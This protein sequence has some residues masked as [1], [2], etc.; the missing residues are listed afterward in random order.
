MLPRPGKLPLPL[1]L[2][3][4]NGIIFPASLP[5]FERWNTVSR[6]IIPINQDAGVL[7]LRQVPINILSGYPNIQLTI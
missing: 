5:D 4:D 2:R 6:E 7:Q 3:F 1:C